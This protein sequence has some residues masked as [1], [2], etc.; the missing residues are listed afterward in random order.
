M[1]SH[2]MGGALCL[3]ACTAHCAVDSVVVIVCICM[4]YRHSLQHCPTE[5]LSLPAIYS[6]FAKVCSGVVNCLAVLHSCLGGLASVDFGSSDGPGLLVSSFLE[7]GVE[8]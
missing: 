3:P 5:A 6:G 2:G 4:R 7:R 1:L 8:T